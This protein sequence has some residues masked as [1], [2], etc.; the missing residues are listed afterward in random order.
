MK[1]SLEIKNSSDIEAILAFHDEL[2]KMDI[3]K[4]IEGYKI[5]SSIMEK[6][7][8]DHYGICE[9]CKQKMLLLSKRGCKKKFCSNRCRS[10]S[11][12]LHKEIE[13]DPSLLHA[14]EKKERFETLRKE[15]V[16]RRA[17]QIPWGERGFNNLSNR[18]KNL[19]Q[20]NKER[21][22]EIL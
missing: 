10:G 16:K 8:K 13:N 18:V 2:D 7:R 5:F 11:Y 17:Y 1:K 20:E 15:I 12:R 19:S 14:E 4:N 22:R 21:L 3:C 9:F 6:W